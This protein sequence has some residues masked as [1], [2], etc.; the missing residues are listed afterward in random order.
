MIQGN[1]S[2]ITVASG[3]AAYWNMA[4]NL[5]R[6]FLA[7]NDVSI[8]NFYI[9][10]DLFANL[11]S[12]LHQIKVLRY[13]SDVLGKGFSSKLQ[14]DQFSQ[15][16]QTLFIDADCLCVGCLDSVFD[17]FQGRDVS[18]IGG[19]I[20]HGEWFGDISSLLLSFGLPS[21]PKFNGGIYYLEKGPISTSV[22]EKARELEKHYD[23]LGLVR[24]RGRPNDEILMALSMGLHGLESLPDDGTIMGDLYACPEILK[25]DV[26][27]GGAL[28][29]NPPPPNDQHRPWFPHVEIEPIIVHFL[30]NFTDGW[31]YKAEA[32][33]L[34]LTMSR[35]WPVC[36][37]EFLVAISFSVWQRAGGVVKNTF[38]PLYHFF[39]GIREIR[40]SPRV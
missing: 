4:V 9:I 21:M 1:R 10:T 23:S 40:S 29:R 18:V 28:L 19:K 36:L 37:A 38:R 13:D 7:W 34:R 39:F 8:I 30:G 5:A 12:D 25:L 33:K 31:Q 24:L 32:M 20:T 3:K 15:T 14:L 27:R 22:Y 2:V 17:R 35:H 26:V 11:P 16:S 6:S